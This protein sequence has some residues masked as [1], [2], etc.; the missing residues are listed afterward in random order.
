MLIL[1]ILTEARKNK[2]HPAQKKLYGKEIFAKY[3]D[4]D[5]SI[6]NNLYVSFT[7]LD[8]L[9]VNPQSGFSTPIGVYTYPIKY[10]MGL[11]NPS[12][13]PWAGDFPNMWVIKPKSEVLHLASYN[14]YESD[15]AK[16]VNFL[17]NRK[18]DA[19]DIEYAVN[20]AETKAPKRKNQEAAKMWRLVQLAANMM[21]QRSETKR[22]N[23]DGDTLANNPVYMNSILRKVLGYDVIR[24]DDVGIIHRHE[25]IQTL[26]LNKES[27]SVVDKLIHNVDSFNPEDYGGSHPI[28]M[29]KEFETNDSIVFL[30]TDTKLFSRFILLTDKQ[31]ML[32]TFEQNTS[33]GEI[34]PVAREYSLM[35][36]VDDF[37]NRGSM[38]FPT[39]LKNLSMSRVAKFIKNNKQAMG[40]FMTALKGYK[41]NKVYKNV[42]GFA[43]E[44]F[45]NVTDKLNI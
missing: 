16:I 17:R 30:P 2:H 39:E 33:T 44:Y 8:K 11:D 20:D 18:E 45:P 31:E 34:Y 14:N 15:K 3:L 24:D 25:P 32:P 7:K 9:G 22:K 5:D 38:T 6:L 12:D 4:M 36:Y 41:T 10:V 29:V 19:D 37:Y 43:K 42:Y 1:N 26:F 27:F 23:E 13:V 35:N 28:K 40:L 21:D